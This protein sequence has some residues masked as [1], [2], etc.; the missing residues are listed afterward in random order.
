M[1]FLPRSKTAFFAAA[2]AIYLSGC[3]VAEEVNPAETSSTTTSSTTTQ[4]EPEPS[5]VVPKRTVFVRNPLGEP[6]ANLLVD[7]DFE[8]SITAGGGQYGWRKF[9]SGGSV[10]IAMTAETGGLCRTGLTCARFKKGEIMFGRGTAAALNKG[11]VM[12]VYARVPEGIACQK[13]NV[14]AVE[15]DTFKPLKA[16]AT[17]PDLENGF[18]HYKDTFAPS[19][20]AVCLYLTNTLPA[21]AVA[22]VDSAVLAPNDGT[23]PY[24]YS[25][26][27]DLPAGTLLTMQ[28]VRDLIH[29]TTRFEK[30]APSVPPP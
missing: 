10:E 27:P 29:R 5:A 9:N 2:F 8:L 30:P 18:C 21:D 7:G 19:S 24:Q 20:S 12:S 14:I 11:H 13:V 15:C 1:S 3:N 6:A 16:S 26:E 17:E 28:N 25:L 22:I 4:P 23:V